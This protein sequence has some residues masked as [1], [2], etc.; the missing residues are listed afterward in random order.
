MRRCFLLLIPLVLPLMAKPAGEFF[1]AGGRSLS[2]GRACV[3]IT[4]FWSVYNN[5]AAN[6]FATNFGSGIS[7]ENRYLIK[8]L[9]YKI[10]GVTIPLRPGN[11]GIIASHFG[12]GSFS[13][14]KAGISFSRKFGKSFA[15]AVQLDYLRIQVGEGYGTKNL[16]SFEVGL[17]YK[18]TRSLSVGLQVINP[19]PILLTTNPREYLPTLI[20]FGLSYTFSTTF[21]ALI[22]L[23]KDLVNRPVFKAG[24]EYRFCTPVAARIGIATNP[25]T[26]TFGFGLIFGRLELDLSSGYQPVLGFTP[27]LSLAYYFGKTSRK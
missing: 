3:G 24:A 25:T 20:R 26:F 9:S 22:E 7:V 11:I 12:S 15:A 19:V 17:F 14:I 16:V 13:E 4:D 21:L 6:G 1:P 18:A 2:M 8:E 27:A 10:I 5:Q 23:E